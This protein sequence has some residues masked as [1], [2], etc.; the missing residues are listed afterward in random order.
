MENLE[1]SN[2]GNDLYFYRKVDCVICGQPFQYIPFA[3]HS[4]M[5]QDKMWWDYLYII[6]DLFGSE[7]SEDNN[8]AIWKAKQKN[9]RNNLG[10]IFNW[11]VPCWDCFSSHK[12]W[13]NE[14][15][16]EI[17]GI[18]DGDET[19]QHDDHEA[20]K[21]KIKAASQQLLVHILKNASK[22]FKDRH[23][24]GELKKKLYNTNM[25]EDQFQLVM[26]QIQTYLGGL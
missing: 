8:G 2:W 26:Q 19:N 18:D 5:I 15:Y 3:I 14:K 1:Y 20:W 13:F 7:S 24:R 22:H 10:Y 12:K 16:R 9:K 25:T 4:L 21:F 6:S 17:M 11:I 23:I